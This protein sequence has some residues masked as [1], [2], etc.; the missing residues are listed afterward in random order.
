[1]EDPD[2][3]AA[4]AALAQENRLKVFRLLVKRGPAGLAAGQIA[5]SVGLAPSALSFHLAHL[6]RAGLLQSWRVRRHIFY[7]VKVEGVRALLM[8]LT[9]DCCQGHPEICAPMLASEDAVRRGRRANG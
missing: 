2:A 7:A 8:F 5:E 1:M 6:E 9:E 4:L 3:I